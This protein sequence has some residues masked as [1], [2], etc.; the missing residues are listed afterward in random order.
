M[1]T[2]HRCQA[3]DRTALIVA[4]ASEGKALL[5]LTGTHDILC[6]F[7]RFCPFCGADLGTE[8]DADA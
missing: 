7:I 4:L 1:E 2:Q 5:A 3:M 6:V 8:E